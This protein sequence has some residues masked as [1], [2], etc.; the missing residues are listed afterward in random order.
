M[1]S[2]AVQ[3]KGENLGGVWRLMVSCCLA[4][5]NVMFGSFWHA[6]PGH[7]RIASVRKSG[8]QASVLSASSPPWCVYRFF[9][10]NHIAQG[11][12]DFKNQLSNNSTKQLK[13]LLLNVSTNIDGK[14]NLVPS[15]VIFLF[16]IPPQALQQHFSFKFS[17]ENALSIS[18]LGRLKSEAVVFIFW[19]H[20]S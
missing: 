17:T 15:S 20:L 7:G 14:S 8:W 12:N 9:K 6:D 16:L 19:K 5:C 4:G 11:W 2:N 18:C 3:K 13:P 10:L 1:C